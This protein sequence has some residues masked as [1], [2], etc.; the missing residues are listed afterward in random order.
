MLLADLLPDDLETIRYAGSLTTAPFT[1]GVSWLVC[2]SVRTVSQAQIDAHVAFVST[3]PPGCA[4]RPVAS[5]RQIQDL[6]GRTIVTD[7]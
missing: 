1:E 4:D 3:L 5:A 2:R 6:V 7:A